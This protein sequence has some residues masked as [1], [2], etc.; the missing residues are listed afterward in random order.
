[1]YCFKL[2]K[3]STLKL[4]VAFCFSLPSVCL[5]A[6]E[7]VPGAGPVPPGMF[8]DGSQAGLP[9]GP[10]GDY[11]GAP[12]G[13]DLPPPVWDP[14]EGE[15]GGTLADL[16][17]W[18]NNSAVFIHNGKLNID[19]RK[20]EVNVARGGK[21]TA[22]NIS[23]V[24]IQLDNI[25]DWT[26]DEHGQSGLVI[27][28]IEGSSASSTI[29]IG[30]SNDY[31]AVRGEGFN[32]VIQLGA[33]DGE[34]NNAKG[35]CSRNPIEHNDET[36]AGLGLVY[37]AKQVRIENV[38]V[39]TDGRG[40]SALMLRGATDSF[41]YDSTFISRGGHG[42]FYTAPMFI[43]L[44]ASA[45]SNLILSKGNTYFFDTNMISTDWG[46]YSLDGV[47]GAHVYMVNSSGETHYGGY[48]MVGLGLGTPGHENWV[49]AYG[50]R[51]V[52]PQYGMMVL[53]AGYV[54]YDSLQ[55]MPKDL[56]KKQ[57]DYKLKDPLNKDGYS[58]VG[59]GIVAVS[60]NS[61]MNAKPTLVGSL[62]ARDTIFTTKHVKYLDGKP[63]PDNLYLLK[64]RYKNDPVKGGT[65]YVYMKY[66]LGSTIWVRSSNIDI[67]FD[68]VELLSASDVIFRTSL[69]VTNPV[70]KVK[71]GV[72]AVGTH[73]N[74][75]NM[76]LKG[77]II[78]DDY[79]RGLDIELKNT[80][81]E[82]AIKATTV[83]GWNKKITSFVDENIDP[84]SPMIRSTILSE[85]MPNKD[86]SAIWGVDIKIGSDSTWVVSSESNVASLTL[87]QKANILAPEGYRLDIASN[88]RMDGALEKYD[89]SQSSHVKQLAPG[90]YRG[91][92]FRL[93]KI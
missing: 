76:D 75:T 58:Y 77:D 56:V 68:N 39:E 29:T 54:S 35:K 47:N 32:S 9:P 4:A 17:Q 69:D 57:G 11:A 83:V 23:G 50:V 78:H 53:T 14:N 30:G 18:G 20:G 13:V 16:A 62:K 92:V 46:N 26:R 66:A 3:G 21:L 2:T 49:E 19:R 41:I 63:V 43:A 89:C 72:E 52:S 31:Y 74:M 1:M 34:L 51:S 24:Q 33:E 27:K 22:N 81:F 85:M 79:Q 36:M 61:D 8:S 25:G 7:C 28:N 67:D 82:G 12:P 44:T 87:D 70:T 10:G 90:T 71:D 84:N 59:G 48:G 65:P 15:P 80:Q 73:L 88:C 64:D 40:R 93:I 60:V 38:L 91:V 86:Y 45:R 5:H 42:D 37:D 55:H 6:Q